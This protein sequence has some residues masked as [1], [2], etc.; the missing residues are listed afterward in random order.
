MNVFMVIMC[1]AWALAE[2]LYCYVSCIG[3]QSQSQLCL[4]TFLKF[5]SSTQGWT[6]ANG[7]LK[8]VHHYHSLVLFFVWTVE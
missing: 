7:Y 1:W 4:Q 5:V 8:L 3:S 6:V 2:A